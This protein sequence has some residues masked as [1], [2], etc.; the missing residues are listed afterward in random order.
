MS[1][2]GKHPDGASTFDPLGRGG[3][4]AT[5]HGPAPYLLALHL[6]GQDPP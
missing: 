2:H 1:F 6:I 5:H 4:V 3:G